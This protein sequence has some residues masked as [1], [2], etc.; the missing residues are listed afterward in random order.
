MSLFRKA[1]VILAFFVIAF[2]ALPPR[3]AEAQGLASLNG[4]VTDASGAIVGD[5]TVKL[6]ST[7]TG[8][9]SSTQTASDGAYRFVDVPP[10]PGYAITVTKSG[11]Q[12]FVLNDVYLPVAT[13]TTKD[14][15]LTIGAVSQTVEVTAG[16]GSVSLNTTDSTI[17]TNLDMHAVESLPDEIRDD[18]GNLLRLSVGVTNA[19]ST[20]GNL[21]SSNEDYNHT[22]DGS[23]AGARTDENNIFVDGVD[24]TDQAIGQAF[25]SVA[26]IPV[27]AIQEFSTQ[28]AEPSAAYGGHSGAQTLITT[29]SG[30][31]TWHGSAYEYNRTAATEANTFFN[32]L[33]SPVVPRLPLIRNQFGGNVGGPVLK[34]KLF[35]F[36]EYDGRRDPSSESILQKIPAPWAQLGEIKYR[37]NTKDGQGTGGSSGCASVRLTSATDTN[38]CI[39]TA[40]ASQV[41]GFDPCSVDNC[42]A[43]QGFVSAGPAP[44][45]LNLFKTRY[46]APNDYSQGDGVNIFGLRFNAPDALTETG[47]LA[48]VDYS[49]TSNNKLFGRFNLQNVST[50]NNNVGVF[51]IQFPSDPLTATQISRDRGWAF[52]DTWTI[53]SNLINQFIYG[54]TRQN[55]QDPVNAPQAGNLYELGWFGSTAGATLAT[56]YDRQTSEGRVVPNPTFRDDITY[57]RG[58]HTIQFGAQFNPAKVRSSLIN[59]FNFISEGIGGSVPSLLSSE[60]PTDISTD[61]GSRTLWDNFFAGELGLIWD[62]QTSINYTKSGT[63]LPSGSGSKRDWRLNNF[64]WYVQ[65][66][67]RIRPDL[68]ATFGLR[69]QYQGAPYE[70]HG[71]EAQFLNT[72]VNQIVAKRL[73]NGL[74]GISGPDA[75]PQL[76][77]QLAGK[78]N[79]AAPLYDA[80]KKDFSPRLSLAWNPSFSE[81][82]LGRAF[83]DRKTVIRA[84]G[85]LIFDPSVV[86]SVTNFED[87]SNYIFGNSVS[88]NFGGTGNPI[89]TEP[90]MNSI[91]APPF[92]IKAP[93]FVNP[94]TPSNVGGFNE[95][96]D[97]TL[98]T[99]YSITASFGVQR[100]LPAGFQLEADYYGRFSRRLLQLADTAQTMDFTDPVSKETLSHAYSVLEEDSRMG[101]TGLPVA[102]VPVQPFF[103]NQMAGSGHCT[104]SCTAYVYNNFFPV[105]QNGGT[106]LIQYFLDDIDGFMAPNVGLTS[107]FAVN[108]LIANKGF[109]GYNGLFVVLRKRLSNNLQFD[110]NYAYSH[111]IDNGSAIGNDNG[112]FDAGSTSVLCDVTN[113]SACRGNSEFDLTHQV[114]ADFVYDLPFGRGQMIGR[115]SNRLVNEAI[116]GW[117]VAGIE[118]W[119]SGFAYTANDTDNAAYDTVSLAADTGVIFNGKRSALKQNIHFDPASG[120]MQLYADPTAAAA[121]FTYVTGL[122]SGDR[123]TLRGPHFSNLDLSVSKNFPLLNERYNLKFVAEAYNVFNHPN[124]GFGDTGIFS[125]SFG[126]ISGQVGAEPSRVMQFAL[127]FSF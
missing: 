101:S 84:G 82:F 11:F 44:E 77:Y 58:K 43:T 10:G 20:T 110:F 111:A 65:D 89:E 7:R 5:A 37:N 83:G 41:V 40:T 120:G 122:Q 61:P 67:W 127:R 52:G 23:V 98:K 28:V 36:F 42:S 103:E 109:A 9:T 87:Q 14:V 68:T 57:T 21:V 80:D 32:K 3:S 93:A 72:N 106:G 123:D 118:T 102:S 24:A 117:E 113:N 71:D 90:R 126:I 114:S 115:D 70:V 35:F 85:G 105:L 125:G 6:Q 56:P 97:P 60:R 124:F 39:S 75:T 22:R 31:N 88:L 112:N 1:L 108:A 18:P 62:D 107:Q 100:E 81:G 95:G 73:A 53:S 46:P 50:G 59:D 17:G 51:P 92:T 26:A 27:D 29:K 94:L 38:S 66:S 78:A 2:I 4:T 34:D 119:H 33:A 99:P 76:A 69:Y 25:T 121:Q 48:R 54:E 8:T 12:T 104:P 19:Q 15:Q 47:Y 30:S 74:A 91:S 13:A 45:I 55:L 16:A 86:Y 63:A 96:I 49:L 64:A 79:N 116:G